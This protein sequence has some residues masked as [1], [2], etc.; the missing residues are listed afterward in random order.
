MDRQAVVREYVSKHPGTQTM[1]LA[2]LLTAC[3]NKHGWP[4]KEVRAII[5]AGEWCEP[6][7]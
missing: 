6:F 4:D 1:T 7:R 3:A 2:K 5:E